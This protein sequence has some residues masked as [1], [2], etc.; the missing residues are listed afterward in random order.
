[1]ITNYIAKTTF[2]GTDYYVIYD[3]DMFGY[4]V[5]DDNEHI[6]KGFYNEQQAV[7][8]LKNEFVGVEDY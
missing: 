5:V 1:M 6:Y 3:N 7:N 4:L 8:Y 2:L